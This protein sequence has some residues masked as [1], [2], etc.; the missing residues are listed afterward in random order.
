ML[1]VLRMIGALTPW[2]EETPARDELHCLAENIYREARGEPVMGQVAVAHVT[3]TRARSAHYP[4]TI[5]GVVH[6]PHQFSWT[7]ERNLPAKRYEP[8][9][10][11][12]E[13]AAHVYAG[14]VADP[15]LGADHYYAP[16]K[17][18]PAWAAE[19]QQTAMIENHRFLKR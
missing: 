17:V 15:T 18:E 9:A 7:R 11:A 6:D 19:L 3:L 10:G 8:W 16:A 4:D 2:V 5:C 13:I 12:V 14:F 1:V